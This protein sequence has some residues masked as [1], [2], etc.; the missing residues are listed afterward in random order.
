M[1]WFT[2]GV[3]AVGLILTMTAVGAVELTRT[4]PQ[5][6]VP[7]INSLQADFTSPAIALGD[8]L[9]PDPFLI[10]CDVK[11]P[12]GAGRWVDP[13][14]WVYTFR[15]P[16]PGAVSCTANINPDFKDV[17]GQA[18]IMAD[19][20]SFSTGGPRPKVRRPWGRTIDED[21]IFV[22]AF[23]APVDAASLA[24]H[25]VCRVQGLGEAAAVRLIQGD[26][27]RDIL[28]A[29]GLQDAVADTAV[30]LLQCKRKL[31]PKAKLRLE[32]LPGVR[33]VAS[34]GQAGVPSVRAYGF[35]Y[36][37]REPFSA[38]MTCT[39]EHADAAC[40]P[41]G[42]VVLSFSAP[43]RAD[44]AP[45]ASL[46]TPAGVRQ[47]LVANEPSPEFVD[48]LRF[49]GPFPERA[50]L[51]LMLPDNIRDD[52]D[53]ALSNQSRFPLEIRTAALP[54]LVKFASGNFGVIER[55]AND[56]SVQGDAIAAVPLAL[57][58][59]GPELLTREL[60][61]SAGTA[62]DHVVTD[63]VQALQW[64]ARVE[65]F[66]G[67][68][69]TARQIEDARALRPLSSEEAEV[70]R[71]DLRSVPLLK[72]QEGVR[73]LRL[74]GVS[75]DPQIEVV[76]VPLDEPGFHILEVESPQLGASLLE[77][78]A[79]MYVRTSVLVTD[80]AVHVKTGRDDM[81]VW[82]TTLQDGRPVAQ[83]QVAVLD[84]AGRRLADGRTDD[85]GVWHRMGAIEDTS[86]CPYSTSGLF[87]TARIPADH[88]QARGQADFSFAWTSWNRGIEP[89]RFPVSTDSSHQADL[90]AH[91]VFDR[92]LLHAGDT[93]SMKL[94]MRRLDRTGLQNPEPS[95]LPA[96][97][98]IEHEGSGE[99]VAID[100]QWLLSPTGGQYALA[101]YA[102]PSTAKLG[103]Y[104]VSL[105]GPD[106]QADEPWRGG[107]YPA[108]EFRVESF[109]LPV[110]T[111][112]LKLTAP[113]A[114]GPLIAP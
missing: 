36:Q 20:W 37:V 114:P 110:F 64:Y 28:T 15:K 44:L 16:V 91:A 112:S 109:S 90:I 30:Q 11:V 58:R 17:N 78:K 102:L 66:D 96:Q 81:L 100:L 49:K 59:V 38:Q 33:T 85:R 4:S 73:S 86:E 18:V 51:R 70:P 89:W 35:D 25:S 14:H 40:S 62:R 5:G 34:A 71:I 94:F 2:K 53:R 24:S 39:R 63:D 12:E 3:V 75:S 88:P 6:L 105:L 43:V 103:R 23:N 26:A 47:A 106:A 77:D 9:A 32:I 61:I 101:Q 31:S 87:V 111:G 55:F 107:Y 84:C 97:A 113:E 72:N 67:G 8:D 68:E 92:S 74:P 19:A 1:R 45:A 46:D 82:V 48:Q 108:G 98:L 57:R 80:L 27:R 65:R 52:A 13:Q 22:L 104:A 79:P 42:D 83:A 60:S 56:A 54:P 95:R 7:R 76:G 29:T 99:R 69:L 50:V 41:L 21:Q 93:V 10:Q